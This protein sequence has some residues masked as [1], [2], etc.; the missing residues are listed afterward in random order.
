M[1]VSG[2]QGTPWREGLEGKEI[3]SGLVVTTIWSRE[4]PLF[5]IHRRY[6]QP[7]VHHLQGWCSIDLMYCCTAVTV[8]SQMVYV[9]SSRPVFFLCTRTKPCFGRE[10]SL[11][12]GCPRE[13]VQLVI[14]S[15]CWTWGE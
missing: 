5:P 8:I 4:N 14:R 1:R 12:E 15:G 7:A 6:G 11:R 9:F 3:H 2:C 13:L 10:C